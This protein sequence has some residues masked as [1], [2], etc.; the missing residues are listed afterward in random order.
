MDVWVI[1]AKLAVTKNLPNDFFRISSEIVGD[2][3]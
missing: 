3:F 1:E 2:M